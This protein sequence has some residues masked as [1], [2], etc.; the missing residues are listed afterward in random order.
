M[1]KSLRWFFALSCITALSL[2]VAGCGIKINTGGTTSTLI[3]DATLATGVDSELKPV[4][5]SNTFPVTTDMLY[6]SFKLNNAPANT[7][8]TARMTYLGGEAA[9]MA[10]QVLYDSS[11]SGEGTKFMSFSMESPPGGFPQGNYQIALAANG[12]ET[13]NMPFTVQN[14]GTQKVWPVISKFSATPDTIS[15]GQPVTLSWEVSGATRLTLQPEVGTVPNSGTRSI[16]PL[17]T[18]TYKLIAS[19]DAGST[20]REI[21]VQVGAAVTGVPDLVVTDAWLEGCMIYYKIKNIGGVDSTPTTSYLYVDNLFPP[22]GANSYCDVLKPGQEKTL[23]FSSYQWLDCGSNPTPGGGGN[24]IFGTLTA[25]RPSSSRTVAYFDPSSLNHVVKVCADGKNEAIEANKNNNCLTKIWGQLFDYNLLPA[26]HLADWRNNSG[27]VPA[28]GTEG[29]PQG[30]YIKMG[31]GGLE[32]VPPQDP[33]GWIQ[34]YWGAF[35]SAFSSGTQTIATDVAAIQIP[36][37]THFICKVGLAKN[38]QGSDGVTFKLGLKDLSDTINF[39][40]GKTM[41]TPGVFEDWDIDLSDYEGQRVYFIL[42]VEAGASPTNDFA[43]WKEGHVMQV[44]P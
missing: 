5:A 37:K 39:L 10:N 27:E 4:N 44:S 29:S 23:S 43:I 14:L 28:F 17:M 3:T 34:G 9:S 11:L 41:T 32:M 31:D 2:L 26:A 20:T 25:L 22:M 15:A 18:T 12:K 38:A 13:I 8:V 7:H 36:A 42:R 40:P 19:N 35:S 21:T 1:M 24:P 16:T 30:A 33:Q 6:L